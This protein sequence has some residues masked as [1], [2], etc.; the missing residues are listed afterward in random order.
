MR[1][2]DLTLSRTSRVRICNATLRLNGS[3]S[4]MTTGSQD[5]SR[6]WRAMTSAIP[7]DTGLAG[8]SDPTSTG[9]RA[10]CEAALFELRRPLEY[11]VVRVEVLE[12]HRVARRD[13]VDADQT[14]PDRSR[15]VWRRNPGRKPEDHGNEPQLPRDPEDAHI[16][17]SWGDRICS[18]RLRVELVDES[19]TIELGVRHPR[20]RASLPFDPPSLSLPN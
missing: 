15:P 9:K 19:V 20:P 13:V 7:A 11:Q 10:P 1:M 6:A 5:S 4:V 12:K 14:P 16:R 3:E 18:R 17:R 8:E 2:T